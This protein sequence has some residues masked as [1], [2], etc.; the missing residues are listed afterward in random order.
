MSDVATQCAPR[1]ANRRRAWY[2]W[3]NPSQ[4]AGRYRRASP[5]QRREKRR[6]GAAWAPVLMF[7]RGRAG[8][9]GDMWSGVL[10]V[11]GHPVTGHPRATHLV[12]TLVHGPRSARKSSIRSMIRQFVL[13]A[14]TQNTRN[15]DGWFFCALGVFFCFSRVSANFWWGGVNFKGLPHQNGERGIP[16]LPEDFLGVSW[17]VGREHRLP[18]NATKRHSLEILACHFR[19]RMH[20]P[21]KTN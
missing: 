20:P 8:A 10:V 5:T 21:K 4:R 7:A 16:A 3:R 14:T 17:K 15:R 6:N 1:F 9:K 2:T 11:F 12:H 19:D 13:E 18:R